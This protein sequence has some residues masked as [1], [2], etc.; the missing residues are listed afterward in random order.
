M[1]R[2]SE[3]IIAVWSTHT[4]PFER[5]HAVDLELQKLNISEISRKH[6]IENILPLVPAFKERRAECSNAYDTYQQFRKLFIEFLQ[7][8]TVFPQN[9][10]DLITVVRKKV[11][12]SY[13]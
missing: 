8:K 11:Q 7:E 12:E 10:D 4:D 1:D 9:V 13:R 5:N 2:F 6:I 3:L